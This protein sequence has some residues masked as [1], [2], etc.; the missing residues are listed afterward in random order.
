MRKAFKQER[1]EKSRGSESTRSVSANQYTLSYQF[2]L[3][4]STDA[5]LMRWPRLYTLMSIFFSL[6]K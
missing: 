2:F 1:E 6:I 5:R 3:H 4:Q